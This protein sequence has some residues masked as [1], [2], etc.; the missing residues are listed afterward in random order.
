MSLSVKTLECRVLSRTILLEDHTLH[1]TLNKIYLTV[2]IV[3]AQP[4]CVQY[5]TAKATSRLQLIPY[6]SGPARGHLSGLR[7]QPFARPV[8][9]FWVKPKKKDCALVP[10]C[11]FSE[12]SYRPMTL[13]TLVSTVRAEL[14]SDLETI[15]P[16][17]VAIISRGCFVCVTFKAVFDMKDDDTDLLKLPVGSQC[18]GV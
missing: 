15:R 6:G 8:D 5:C 16:L 13:E 10:E 1:A 4:E 18:Y 17:V 14:C 11:C 2:N 9:H 3:S 12:S 7:R